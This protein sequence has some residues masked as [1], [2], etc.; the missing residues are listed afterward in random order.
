MED[1]A[2][3]ERVVALGTGLGVSPLDISSGETYEV[4]HGL[5]SVVSVE[6]DLDGAKSGVHRGNCSVNRHGSIFSYGISQNAHRSLTGEPCL[7]L[8]QPTVARWNYGSQKDD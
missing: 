6:V 8:S 7:W 2:V 4:L 1:N 3:V 5:R